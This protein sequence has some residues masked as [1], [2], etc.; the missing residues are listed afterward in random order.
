MTNFSQDNKKLSIRKYCERIGSN[1]LFV[2]GAGGNISWKEG[3]VLW[4]K[5]SGMW[6]I[7]ATK[8][9]IF[10]PVD[11]KYIKQE[12]AKKKYSI[13]I[14]PIESSNLRPSIETILHAILPHNV[15]LHIHAVEILASLVSK[16]YASLISSI[17]GKSYE[18]AYVDYKK[19]GA[20]LAEAVGEVV[21]LSTNV[22][23]IFLQN[24]GIVIGGDDVNEINNILNNLIAAIESYDDSKTD[25]QRIDNSTLPVIDD[26]LPVSDIELHNLALNTEYYKHVCSHW[27]LY[28]D[29]VV[30]LGKKPFCYVNVTEFLSS[31][32][33]PDLIFI[34][35]V[36]VYVALNFNRAKEAQLRCYYDVISRIKNKQDLNILSNECINEL[37]DWDQE[38]YRIKYAK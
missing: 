23:I 36:G 22:Q 14:Q 30:F 5:A 20:D 17:I 3:D 38:K 32:E 35:G 28:P 6:L 19:P 29:H 24:H 31:K 33:N 11:L 7:D 13:D 21:T 37:L 34:K 18:C 2:Q 16:D 27:A 9:N 12:V 8:E 1:P 25:C 26:Y 15:V 4:V 10:V